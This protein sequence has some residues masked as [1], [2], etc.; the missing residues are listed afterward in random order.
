MIDPLPINNSD[1]AIPLNTSHSLIQSLKNNL[2]IVI[3]GFLGILFIVAVG[4]LMIFSRK[5]SLANSQQTSKPIIT[6]A[7]NPWKASE[8]NATI[9]KILIEEHLGYIVQLVNVDENGQWPMLA[10]GEIDAS[11]EV[12]PSGHKQNIQKYIKADKTVEEG[13][14]LG[15]IG[16]IGWYIPKYLMDKHPDLSSWEGFKDPKNVELFV[17]SPGGKGQFYTG[18]PTWT[19]YDAQIIKNLGLNFEVQTLG[20]EDALIQAV[21]D[22]YAK[23]KP[24]V[25][26]FWTPH[27]AD[28]IYDLEPVALPAYNELCYQDLVSGVNCDYPRDQLLKVFWSGF[29]GYA[30]TVYSFLKKFTYTNQDQIGMLASVQLKKNSVEDVARIWIK[31]NESVWKPWLQ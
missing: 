15:P 1:P 26:Y 17:Q 7:V 5:N 8:L 20:S 23:E 6:I 30:P 4:L 13:G 22:A 31:N 19:Q 9:A 14:Y 27:W 3:T 16:K 24:I 12:W 29:N 10:K 28:A 2:L 18:D 25:F 21:G 11:L